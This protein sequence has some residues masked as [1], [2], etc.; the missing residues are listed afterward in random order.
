MLYAIKKIPGIN[1]AFRP[2]PFCG[3][4]PEW[5]L[6]PGDEF[7][8]RCSSCHASTRMAH[9]N[10]EEAA[11]EWNANEIDDDHFDITEDVK[12]DEYLKHGI[13]DVLFSED[14]DIG[15]F[16]EPFP[17]T[18][19]GFLCR[20]AVIVK[21]DMMIEIQSGLTFQSGKRCL[22]YK[23]DCSYLNTYYTRSIAEEGKGI[24]FKE[25]KWKEDNLFSVSF[26]CEGKTITISASAE[27]NCL[28]VCEE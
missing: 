22:R 19:D 14:S 2:C 18:D 21:D 23:D 7:V 16:M 17:M 1:I 28:I 13:K 3:N 25:S 11:A 12:I 8:M 27:Y 26:W 15:S 4:S 5:V 20:S 9:W 24:C 6:E 10:P